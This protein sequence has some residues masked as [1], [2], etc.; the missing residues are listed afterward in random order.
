VTRSVGLDSADTTS[1]HSG[2][3]FMCENQPGLHLLTRQSSLSSTSSLASPAVASR[4]N[5]TTCIADCCA[6]A[7]SGECRRYIEQ[8][9]DLAPSHE[10]TLG[11]GSQ[12][13]TSLDIRALCIAA[14][15]S[16]LCR[17]RVKTRI[18]LVRA[19]VSFHQLRTWRRTRLCARGA[20]YGSMQ[21]SKTNPIRSPRRQRPARSAAQ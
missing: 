7:A 11:R 19:Y 10:L 8:G 5:P 2:R 13:S 6:R 15:Y 18:R 14:K 4:R 12:S 21:C 20:N 9:D 16:R 17:L 1:D 3:I